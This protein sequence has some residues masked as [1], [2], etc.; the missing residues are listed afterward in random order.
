[1]G[2]P[3]RSR[4]H[5]RFSRV[6]YVVILAVIASVVPANLAG[7]VTRSQVDAA[8]SESRT[9]YNSYRAAQAEFE[10]ATNELDRTNVRLWD[11][12]Y[13]IGRAHV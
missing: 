4:I 10:S 12:E 13:Q 11:A 5:S 7:A 1:M 2:I 6:T 9:A 8:C 3:M